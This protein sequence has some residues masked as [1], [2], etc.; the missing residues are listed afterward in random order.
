[1]PNSRRPNIARCTRF[2]PT[3]PASPRRARCAIVPQRPHR[4]PGHR[5]PGRGRGDSANHLNAAS[6]RSTRMSSVIVHRPNQAQPQRIRLHRRGPPARS[7]RPPGRRRRGARDYRQEPVEA[8]AY[9]RRD[10]HAVGRRRT[11][12]VEPIFDAARQLKRDV[13]GNRIVIFAP[14]YIG[15]DCTNDCQYCASAARTGRRCA[16]AG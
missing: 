9:D 1:M 2:I 4:G 11:A 6:H 10:G 12:L 15:N 5:Q 8:A 13:Y 7:A 14:L 16:A 3:K